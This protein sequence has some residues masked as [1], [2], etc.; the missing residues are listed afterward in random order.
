MI[1]RRNKFQALTIDEIYHK[2]NLEV[3]AG[4]YTPIDFG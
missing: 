4:T 3:L 1:K 2:E